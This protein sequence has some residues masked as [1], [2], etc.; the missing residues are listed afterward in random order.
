MGERDRGSYRN[1]YRERERERERERDQRLLKYSNNR[2]PK[3]DKLIN[4]AWL[5][6]QNLDDPALQ[7]FWLQ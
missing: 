7:V 5:T 4:G 6:L 1:I 2:K 3:N